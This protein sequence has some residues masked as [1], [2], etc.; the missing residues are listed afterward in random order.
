MGNQLLVT[1]ASSLYKVRKKR[2]YSIWAGL[3]WAGFYL[4]LLVNCRSVGLELPLLDLAS[5]M[6]L[7]LSRIYISHF[8]IRGE[9]YP[10]LMQVIIPK[11]ERRLVRYLLLYKFTMYL[12]YWTLGSY[13]Q[14]TS[15]PPSPFYRSGR[16]VR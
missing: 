16:Y 11:A 14:S 3:G 10:V 4:Y 6:H 7:V 5:S 1:I 2:L 13:R 15:P 9:E 8:E 12:P